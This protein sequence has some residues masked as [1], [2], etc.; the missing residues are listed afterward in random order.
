MGVVVGGHWGQATSQ[1]LTTLQ[2]TLVPALWALHPLKPCTSEKAGLSWGSGA[3]HSW[4]GVISS[5]SLCTS[6]GV[7][8]LGGGL[9]R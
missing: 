6:L 7:A 1:G 3:K 8:V 2:N 4:K 5:F 9:S